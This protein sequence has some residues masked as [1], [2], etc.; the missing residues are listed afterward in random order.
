MSDAAVTTG[1]NSAG[2]QERSVLV[3]NHFAQPRTSP[4]GTR[5]VELFSRLTGW[6]ARVIASDRNM[7]DGNQVVASGVLE[8]VAVTPYKGNGVSRILNW[9][10]YAVT[11]FIRGVTAKPLD[12]VYGSS[13]HLL[14]ALSGWAIARIRR[15]PFVLEVRDIWPQ[16]LADMGSLSASSAVFRVLEKLETFLYRRADRIVYMAE[17][18]R[19]HVESRGVDPG[20][21][22]F[23]PNGADAADFVPSGPRDQ[24]REHYGF[25]GVVAVYAGAHGPANGLDLLI[26]AAAELNHS[27]PELHIVLV[28]A[29][30]LKQQLVERVQRDGVTNVTFM[31][32]IPKAEIPDLLAAADIGVHC[33]ADVELFRSGVSPNKLFDYMAAGM[34]VITNTPGIV[35]AFVNASG[36]GVAV[37]P[38]ELAAGLRKLADMP[39]SER[40]HLGKCGQAHLEATRSRTAMAALIEQVLDEAYR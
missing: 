37:A 40:R 38:G 17:G 2:V 7:L 28:G 10:S 15:K 30:A 31:L 33:L 3:L 1:P 12:V 22:V 26:N 13:P 32:P 35:E 36:G 18:V 21:L 29:G 27:V 8:T 11:S 4:G 23:I 14:A 5:H 20:R 34:P 19:S 9:C 6:S 24:L 39:E 25:T 16:V